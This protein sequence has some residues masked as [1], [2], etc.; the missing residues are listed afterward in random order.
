MI[1]PA[2][3]VMD[4]PC[5]RGHCERPASPRLQPA[6]APEHAAMSTGSHTRSR[7][8]W[9]I[10][11]I[12]LV[13]ALLGVSL[14]A[15]AFRDCRFAVEPGRVLSWSLNVRSVAVRAD[16]S[17]GAA[18]ST[19]HRLALVGLGP[20]PGVVAWLAGPA[21]AAPVS[22]RAI[23]LATD[24]R[25]RLRGADGRL[26]EIGPSLAGFD[27]N[28]LPLPMGAEQEWKPEVVWSALPDGHRTVN[29]SAKRLRSGA[30]PQ[31]R[32]DFPVSVEWVDPATGRYRQVRDLRAT[33]RF[34][35][36]RGLPREA[37]V[38]FT[39]RDELPPPGGFTS[40]RIVID[41]AYIGSERA[42]DPADLREAAHL[43]SQA[44]AWMAARRVPPADLLARLR[45]TTGPFRA[46]A[47]GLT[48]RTRGAR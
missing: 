18:R 3:C 7:R 47:E 22:M 6:A 33:Y 10:A 36:L 4:S 27:F 17:D 12:C 11:G 45:A 46:L 43:A 44:E 13:I 25:V 39:M 23:D 48:A 29:C 35:T 32:C 41:L 16:G 8:A 31:F 19:V 5:H 26:T 30:S 9:W 28:L 24:G 34:D 15:L 42:G 21:G 38:T 20:E 37:Q 1:G 40:S 14:F 2:R